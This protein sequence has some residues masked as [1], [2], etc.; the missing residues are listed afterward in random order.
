MPTVKYLF[1]L[2]F[3][4]SPFF[5]SAQEEC[6]PNVNSCGFYLC[7]EKHHQ[8][9]PKGYPIGFGFKFC[10]IYLNGEKSYSPKAHEWLRKV[11]ICLM[12]KFNETEKE[13]NGV[14]T[15]GAIKSDSFH[16]HVGCYVKT[17]FCE[18]SLKDKAQIFWAMRSSLIHTEI[19][20]DAIGVSKACDQ[21]NPAPVPAFSQS[22]LPF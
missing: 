1:V 18:L 16:S 10:Q 13:T 22:A 4:I 3:L 20:Q 5:V 17:G 11:R 7:Q 14:R 8:C 2:F 21:R 12:E 9:G 6:V 15:C 19:Y